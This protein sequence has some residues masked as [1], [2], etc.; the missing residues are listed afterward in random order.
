MEEP[1]GEQLIN[2]PFCDE[3]PREEGHFVV[4]RIWHETHDRTIVQIAATCVYTLPEEHAA[5]WGPWTFFLVEEVRFKRPPRSHD[6]PAKEDQEYWPPGVTIDEGDEAWALEL[7][8]RF[9]GTPPAL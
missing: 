5:D 2:C 6:A 3:D 7:G 1:K 4:S 8:K 9:E